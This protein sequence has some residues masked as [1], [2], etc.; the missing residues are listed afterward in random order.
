MINILPRELIV[1]I[2]THAIKDNFLSVRQVSSSFK[3]IS[4]KIEIEQGRLFAINSA[5][6]LRALR[7]FPSYISKT[8]SNGNCFSYFYNSGDYSD[9]ENYCFDFIM[10]KYYLKPNFQYGHVTFLDYASLK[11]NFIEKCG[12]YPNTFQIRQLYCQLVL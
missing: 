11:K 1:E 4:E 9:V 10:G 8:R 5:D 12:Y 3:I 2:L 6:M 7:L